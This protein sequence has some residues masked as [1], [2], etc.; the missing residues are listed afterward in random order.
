[1]TITARLTTPSPATCTC[2]VCGTVDCPSVLWLGYMPPPNHVRRVGDPHAGETW[3][4]AELFQCPTC[5]LVQLGCVAPQN[6]LFPPEYPFRSGTTR[7]RRDN[8][9]DLAREATGQLGMQAGDLVVDVGANDGTLLKCFQKLGMRVV[10]IEPTDAASD[11]GLGIPMIS[12]FLDDDTVAGVLKRYGPAKLVTACNVL[13]HMPDPV[14]AVQRVRAMLAPGGAFVSESHYLGDLVS[15]LQFDGV[16]HERLRHYSVTALMGLL[17]LGSMRISGLTRIPTEGGSMRVYAVADGAGDHTSN[18]AEDLMLSH[19]RA[20]GLTDGRWAHEFADRLVMAKATLYSILVGRRHAGELVLGVGAPSRASS[21]AAYVGL[22]ASVVECA[23]EVTE[24]PR[25]GLYIAG[26]DIP[27]VDEETVDLRR[28]DHALV[29]A[30]HIADELILD[31]KLR[32]F[33]GDFILPLPEP[34]VVRNED[35]AI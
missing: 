17:R 7:S 27:I 9:E 5:T 35:V 18:P 14:K 3:Y 19:E 32:G 21:L 34:R 22:D 12:G 8:F 24:S 11:A 26:T 33:R 25:V 13:A 29:L 30:W 15:E 1:M 23:C 31:F 6:E 16:F 10:G 2:Q 28:Y 4:P 20:V